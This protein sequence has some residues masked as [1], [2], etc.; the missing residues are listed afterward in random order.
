M[1]DSRDKNRSIG[2]IHC[3]GEGGNQMFMHV[4]DSGEIRE[5]KFCLDATEPGKPVKLLDCHGL[6]GNQYWQYDKKVK[7]YFF[8]IARI[9]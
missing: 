6:G 7:Q 8:L 1:G 5:Q 2:I 3:H 4:L 9:Y